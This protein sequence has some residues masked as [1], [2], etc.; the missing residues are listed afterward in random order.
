MSKTGAVRLRGQGSA[1]ARRANGRALRGESL[2]NEKAKLQDEL[3][4]AKVA[5]ASR[6]PSTCPP[7]SASPASGRL[8]RDQG[9]EFAELT[10]RVRTAEA[11]A[12]HREREL[13]KLRGRLEHAL[14][15]DAKRQA[16]ALGCPLA[17]EQ[18]ALL[19]VR[20]C[21]FLG[22]VALPTGARESS[23][24][25]TTAPTIGKRP[26]DSDRCVELEFLSLLD[27][28]LVS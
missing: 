5:G 25:K 11:S 24:H 2:L 20:M 17:L 8:D 26:G 18:S 23:A 12:R 14:A 16:G 22:L 21:G 28:V 10:L 13:Q 9:R 3:R 15:E 1:A 19:S 6:T 4:A 27:E 7:S